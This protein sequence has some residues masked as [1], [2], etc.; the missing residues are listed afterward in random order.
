MSALM[1]VC[2]YLETKMHLGCQ[3]LFFLSISEQKWDT[4]MHAYAH[5][6]TLEGSFSPMG[7][8]IREMSPQVVC[9]CRS[10]EPTMSFSY[11]LQPPCRKG[12]EEEEE[13]STLGKG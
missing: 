3:D 5:T 13:A 8:T 1:S 12:S 2:F 4:H 6:H 7:R 10:R 9:I 11:R